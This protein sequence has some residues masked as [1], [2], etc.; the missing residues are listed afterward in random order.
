MAVG[1]EECIH[2]FGRGPRKKQ[3]TRGHNNKMDL[4]KQDTC[5]TMILSI[6]KIIVVVRDR[7]IYK[8][9]TWVE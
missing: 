4:K 2:C 9:A 6:P 5:N 7:Q 3:T 1:E 8:H